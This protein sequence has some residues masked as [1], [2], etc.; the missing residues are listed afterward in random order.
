MKHVDRKGKAIRVGDS[1]RVVEIPPDV[2][3]YES[4]PDAEE[5]EAKLV[6]QRSLGRTFPI[7]A[8]DDERVELLVGS[9]MKRSAYEHTIFLEPRFVE[10][11]RKRKS[12]VS[13]S[14]RK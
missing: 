11:A 3:N 7:E 6:F 1:V 9:V 2:P 8:F 4:S 13:K 10:L 14:R 12:K 5:M